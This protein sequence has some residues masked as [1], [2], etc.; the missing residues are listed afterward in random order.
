M[1]HPSTSSSSGSVT[2]ATFTNS[3]NGTGV[4]I[5][6]TFPSM[7]H[8]HSWD[9]HPPPLSTSSGRTSSVVDQTSGLHTVPRSSRS[10]VDMPR[11]GPFMQPFLVGHTHRY[12]SGVIFRNGVMPVHFALS[13]FLSIYSLGWKSNGVFL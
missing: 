13:A 10:N 11:P 12:K 4:E 5:G 7:D 2:D 3:W 1:D 6:F 8:F 9:H